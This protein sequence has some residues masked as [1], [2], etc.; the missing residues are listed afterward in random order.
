[1]PSTNSETIDSS[2]ST[3][4][5]PGRFS[6][7]ITAGTIDGIA[8]CFLAA[9]FV[10]RMLYA[11][12]LGLIPDETYYW[13]WS[14]ELSFGYYDHPPMVAWLIFLSR[15]LFGES[16][17]GVRGVMV[18]CSFAA[19]LCSYFLAKKFVA[20][21]S[22][23]IFFLVLSSS[24]LLFGVGTMLS[25]PDVPLVLFWSCCLLFGYKAVFEESTAAW[26]LL[27]LFAGCGLLSKYT[28][29]LF[30]AA[31]LLFILFSKSKRFWLATWQ[32]YAAFFISM[33][34]WLPNI[35]WNSR[36]QWISFSFQ[37]SH[38]VARHATIKLNTLG[39]FIGGQAGILS[40]FP[41]ILLICACAAL[42]KDL[43]RK[44]S[45]VAY[46]YAFLFTPFCVF[47]CA[48]MQNKVE[49]NW[50]A[51]AYVS[52]MILIAR[53]WDILDSTENRR[54][55]R[56]SRAMRG[57]ALFSVVFA[58]LTT[59]ILLFHIQR[60]FLPLAPGNDPAVQ[61][62]GWKEWANEVDAVRNG[63][64]PDRSLLVCTNRYQEASM[65][66]FY[67]PD[68]PKTFSLCLGA[69]P[70]NYTLFLERKP[71]AFQ[72]IIFIHPAEDPVEGPLFSETFFSIEKKG[73]V[74]L[75]QAPR[76]ANS[77]NIYVA[78]LRKPL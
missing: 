77:Y 62:R 31:F 38:G 73:A 36:H 30:F 11:H 20:R 54:T 37:F 57:F 68:H 49:A 34:V 74:S 66:G 72:K 25:T 3:V 8:L 45:G 29:T 19:S 10:F 33:A 12:F 6:R 42:W 21:P 41:F 9:I 4:N 53:Y 55:S 46:L 48:S 23:L 15:K 17:L 50:A 76:F 7:L 60:P 44:N 1:M 28:F 58:A 39:E 71:A 67:L 18:A 5:R 14:R 47:L 69:R 56:A 59:A 22:S 52:G 64:D 43:R 40:V 70:N 16:A 27:G 63:I 13:D 26:L 35:L 61:A 65:L 32:P 75:R 24:I 51:T 78:V 2:S